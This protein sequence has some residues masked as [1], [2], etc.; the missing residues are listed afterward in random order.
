MKNNMPSVPESD[1]AFSFERTK[2]LKGMLLLG[3]FLFHFCNFFPTEVR[4]D[5][6]HTMVGAFFMLSG[7]GLLESF[8][9]KK[10]YLDEFVGKK[11]A[12]LLVPVWIAGV[13][14]LIFKWIVF[15]NHSILN[16]HIY[17][18]DIISGG[19]TTTATWFVV[20]LIFFYLFFYLAFKHLSV[21]WGIVAVSS[22]VVLLM[23]LLSQQ[24]GMWYG[25]GMMFPIGL[26]IS[27]Y[28][29]RIE[30]IKPHTILI[31][32]IIISLIFAY[33]MK[34]VR[35]PWDSTLIY[36]NLQCLFVSLLAIMSLL[37]RK[38]GAGKWLISLLLCNVVYYGL[39]ASLQLGP[40]IITVMPVIT[41]LLILAGIDTFAPLT[42]MFG[43]IS[44]EF[45]L[46]HATMIFVSMA[47]FS[48]MVLCF[49]SSLVLAIIMAIIINKVTKVFIDDKKKDASLKSG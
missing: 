40:N 16:E 15:A 32:S 31:V 23:I 26:M 37:S 35:L 17:L 33:Y 49:V 11:T 28:R 44:Y 12:R 1:S 45:Y 46:I 3:V 21:R 5:I 2:R 34:M 6:G 19:T 13:I 43:N 42:K 25:S 29:D 14:V 8:K 47:W 9:R 41:V 22:A 39:E 24:Q 10:N 7:F 36:G 27:Y 4:P 48:D 20:E 38:T 30:S 18:F